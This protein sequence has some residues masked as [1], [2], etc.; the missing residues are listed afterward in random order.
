MTRRELVY[1]VP[2]LVLVGIFPLAVVAAGYGLGSLRSYFFY[3]LVPAAVAFLI[4]LF[5]TR[6]LGSG[7]L[8]NRLAVGVLAG[9]AL[10][11]A[12]D[13]VRLTGY[14]LGFLPA[15]MPQVFGLQ[16][17]GEMPMKAQPT[18]ASTFFGYLYHFMNGVTFGVVYSL[19][20]GRA[21]WWAGILYSVFFVELG[22]MT[23]PPMAKATG[24]FGLG[25][26]QGILNGVFMTTLLAHVAMGVVLGLIVQRWA[27]GGP[28]WREWTSP[29]ELSA[30]VNGSSTRED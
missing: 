14:N 26:G 9:I 12:L 2:P 21:R 4:I 20:F 11:V 30:G 19:V 5:A 6:R 27:R 24:P 7:V 29:G 25:L 18:Q 22:M 10:T 1:A 16:I 23:L 13:V 28:I 3:L 8:F 15:N 17:V